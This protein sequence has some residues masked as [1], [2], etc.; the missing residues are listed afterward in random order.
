MA[1]F[2]ITS[3]KYIGFKI[4]HSTP[5]TITNL[6]CCTPFKKVTS[7]VIMNIQWIVTLSSDYNAKNLLNK[8]K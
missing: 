6:Y 3:F 4:Y 7:Y 2:I 1:H 8:Q 5:F